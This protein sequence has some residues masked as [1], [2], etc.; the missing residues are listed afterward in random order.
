[1]CRIK[2]INNHLWVPLL[3]KSKGS[4]RK[5]VARNG[6][7]Q[8]AYKWKLPGGF[9]VKFSKEKKG[10]D[11]KKKSLV[12]VIEKIPGDLDTGEKKVCA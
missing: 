11:R 8:T 2:I 12:G 3:K 7:C 1:M 4:D 10:K 6:R 5:F 9:T